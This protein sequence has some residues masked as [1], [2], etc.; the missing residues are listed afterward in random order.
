MPHRFVDLFLGIGDIRVGIEHIQHVKF[1]GGQI[2]LLLVDGGLMV[3][4]THMQLGG[5]HLD[6]EKFLG[7][8]AV[9]TDLY[10]GGGKDAIPFDKL[11]Q[12]FSENMR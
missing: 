3:S 11:E 8:D 5:G 10:D 9:H 6:S 4:D 1:L 12:F 7:R 2:D